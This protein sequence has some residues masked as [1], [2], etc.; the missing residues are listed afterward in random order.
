MALSIDLLKVL[1]CPR[2]KGAVESFHDGTAIICPECRLK[3][4]VRDSI[5]VMLVDEAEQMGEQG[6]ETGD[7]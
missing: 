6:P 5:P 4:P 1:A 3:Y 2:C 7:R